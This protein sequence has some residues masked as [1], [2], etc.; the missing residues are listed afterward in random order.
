MSEEWLEPVHIN[1]S[2]N[3]K[4]H[5]ST[6][7]FNEADHIYSLSD[8]ATLELT[9]ATTFIHRYFSP[10]DREKIASK[11]IQNVPKYA[12][13]TKEELFAD[14]KQSGVSGTNVHN[15]LEDFII[16]YNKDGGSKYEKALEKFCVTDIER[17]KARQGMDWLGDNVFGKDKLKLLPEVKVVTRDYKIA[18]MMDL[19][20]HDTEKDEYTILDWKTNKRISKK[21]YGGVVGSRECTSDLDDCNFIHYTLQLSLY[22]YILEREYGLKITKQALIHVSENKAT[23]IETEYY[24]NSI[25][26]M[27][28]DAIQ[29]GELTWSH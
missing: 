19:L 25:V 16:Y 6:L 7:Q 11:L 12:N 23:V 9:S 24:R 13:S 4:L 14:W 20:V 5:D 2:P 10:F 15:A 17:N 28:A 29:R 8:D 1:P 3:E 26:R 21:S 27:F 22:R 18:G